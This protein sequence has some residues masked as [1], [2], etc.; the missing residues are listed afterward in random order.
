MPAELPLG[1]EEGVR[2]R[3]ITSLCGM[4]TMSLIVVTVEGNA[5]LEPI[6]QVAAL[7]L[8]RSHLGRHWCVVSPLV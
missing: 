3:V 2:E 8:D 5:A 6:C 4:Y 7:D 1:E